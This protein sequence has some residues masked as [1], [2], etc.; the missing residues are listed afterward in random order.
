LLDNTSGSGASGTM[1]IHNLKIRPLKLNFTRGQLGI[2]NI[3]LSYLN[4][5]KS[6]YDSV[7]VE[8]II[9]SSMINAG[10]FFKPRY[11]Q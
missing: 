9:Q 10:S 1:K 7:K 6:K 2:K 8:D 5:E 4:I 11:I 3:I